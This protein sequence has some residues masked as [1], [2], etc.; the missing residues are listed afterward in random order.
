MVCWIPWLSGVKL[1]P[2]T[3]ATATLSPVVILLPIPF[4]AAISGP[5]MLLMPHSTLATVVR[6]LLSPPCL[7]AR[8]SPLRTLRNLRRRPTVRVLLLRLILLLRAI[9]RS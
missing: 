1:K 7:D 9:I 8:L 5:A 3:R 4:A 6:V 2:V